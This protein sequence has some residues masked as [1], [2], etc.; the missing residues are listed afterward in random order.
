VPTRKPK[1]Q[2]ELDEDDLEDLL[3]DAPDD[4]DDEDELLAYFADRLDIDD[5][6]IQEMAKEAAG[7]A[8]VL[9]ALA[10]LELFSAGWDAL[11]GAQDDATL[12]QTEDVGTDLT[13][14]L[15]DIAA[16][17]A[18]DLEERLD[19]GW[20]DEDGTEIAN[21]ADI[22]AQSE[23]SES[24]ADA[25]VEAGWE[26]LRYVAEPDACDDCAD[27]DDTVLPSDDP[28]WD[29]HTPPDLHIN[30]RCALVPLSEDEAEKYGISK[31]APDVDG[32]TWRDKPLDDF[33]DSPPDLAAIAHSK[34]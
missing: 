8:G 19:T 20:G 24:K 32:G 27:C 23:Y 30:C 15:N 25:D 12:A 14:R 34:A 7:E 21:L 22:N 28:F 29:D 6:S 26:Y 5:D 1:P 3:E 31:E 16:D 10:F 2:P 13:D 18:D 17:M 4:L 33:S 11:D 9:A